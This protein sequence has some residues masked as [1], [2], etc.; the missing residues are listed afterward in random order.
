MKSIVNTSKHLGKVKVDLFRFE[1]CS[2]WKT[3]ANFR[4]LVMWENNGVLT[5]GKNKKMTRKR[6]NVRHTKLASKS[7]YKQ[8]LTLAL[9]ALMCG[10]GLVTAG[11]ANRGLPGGAEK[12]LS[13]H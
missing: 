5:Y 10:F 4:N 9:R 12:G 11:Q 3:K 7:L 1:M 8:F 13:Q 6:I 2:L